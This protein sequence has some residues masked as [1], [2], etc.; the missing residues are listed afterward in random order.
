[1]TPHL[2]RFLLALTAIFITS[3][4]LATQERDKPRWDFQKDRVLKYVFK[5]KEVRTVEIG[6][7]TLT[8]TTVHEFAWRWTVQ[9]VDERGALI[10]LKFEKLRATVTGKDFDFAYESGKANESAD[11]LKKKLIT[12]YDQVAFGTFRLRVERRGVVSEVKGFTKLC[13]DLGEPETADMFGMSLRDGMLDWFLQQAMGVLPEV[14]PSS[15][16]DRWKQSIERRFEQGQMSGFDDYAL[17][18]HGKDALTT[19]H[20]GQYTLDVDMKWSGLSLRGPLKTS[21]VEGRHVW[22]A[23]QRNLGSG[24]AKIFSDGSLK[25]NNDGDMKLRYEHTVEL[26]RQP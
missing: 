26:T 5:Q 12:F 8:A 19:R 22:D 14:L 3:S 17:V 25:L 23:R 16:D 11:P 2:S 6:D 15:R 9:E 13:E 21:K 7:Q 20:Q 18:E 1:M 24:E 10:E 4:A